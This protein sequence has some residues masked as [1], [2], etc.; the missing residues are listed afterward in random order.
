ME[1]GKVEPLE[2]EIQL[3]LGVFQLKE[4]ELEIIKEQI[5]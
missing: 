4:K 1:E 2:E 5:G 3:H